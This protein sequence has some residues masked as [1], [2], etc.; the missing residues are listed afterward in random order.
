MR[1]ARF[2]VGMATAALLTAGLAGPALAL[3]PRVPDP[4]P[5]PIPMGN[6]TVHLETVASGLVTPVTGAVAPGDRKHLYVGEQ[7]GHVWQIDLR[8]PGMAPRLFADLSSLVVPLGCFGIN[9][10]ERGSFGIAFHPDYK[11]NGLLYTFTSEPP[12]GQPALPPNQCNARTP[13]HDN[14]V[15]EWHV[16]N[17]RSRWATVDASSAREVLRNPQPQ[18][19]HNGGELRF[20]PDGYLYVS[21]GD[22][23]NAD[24]QGPGHAAGGNAQDLSSLN[25]KIL[26][27]DPRAGATAPGH[28]IP[29]DNPFVG[30]AGARGEIWALGFR[31]PFK[32]SFDRKTGT[33]TV[34][35]VGQNDVEEIDRVVGGGNYGWP[36][37]EG[38]FA[39][40]QN[41]AADG[42]VTADTVTG[43]Y[44]DPI[45]QYDHCLGP[46]DPALAGPCP[47]KEG[48]AIV[49]GFVYRGHEAEALRG[50]YVFGDYSTGFF[51]SDGRLFYLDGSN[52]VNELRL[53]TGM[54]LG[55]GVL[56]FAEDARGEIYVFAKS[57]AAFP[58]TGI[59]D[60]ANTTGVVLRIT[61]MEDDGD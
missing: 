36:V 29:A 9:Y 15:T 22:G 21:I 53:D 42:F 43:P 31:N 51:K 16:M 48:S 59:T 12:L 44:I 25:G 1:R 47:V 28:A 18:F 39:F 57:G 26:R 58:N 8:H 34:G 10:D 41:G 14:V 35:D 50:R 17:P 11:H 2:A 60:P 4:I 23:G 20:G 37:K 32:M 49:G 6:V 13:D 24:D 40:D 61:G 30:T 56:G 3:G 27:I 46:V 55:M 52:A 7:N 33:L 38:T 5:D 45:A 19:N 54:P